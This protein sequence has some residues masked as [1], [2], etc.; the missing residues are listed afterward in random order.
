MCGGRAQF[1]IM[2]TAYDPLPTAFSRPFQQLV[3]CLLRADPDDRPTCQELLQLPYVRKHLQML[4]GQAVAR[5]EDGARDTVV[6]SDL[7]RAMP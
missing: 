4:M 5:G 2:R 6:E 3:S 1:K 7:L